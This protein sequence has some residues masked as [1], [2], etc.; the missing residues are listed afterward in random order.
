MKGHAVPIRKLAATAVPLVLAVIGLSACTVEAGPTV[1]GEKLA[2]AAADALEGQL[3][4]RPEVD[5]GGD[6]IIVSQGKKVDCLM[7][8]PASGS[9]F[10]ATVTFTGVDGA[11]WNITV[12]VAAEPN[13]SGSEPSETDTTESTSSGAA[14]EIS[15]EKLAAAAADA[16]EG[17]I[18]TRPQIDCGDLNLTIYEGRKT[19]CQLID[20]STGAEYEVTISVTSIDGEAFE[21]DVQVANT[22][23]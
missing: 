11:E 2:E 19:Y 12:D 20:S 22:P 7:T 5:C 9:E 4:A 13:G 8:D 14:L 16:L 3:G 17:E 18:G 1:S 15:A 21:F 10:D 23:G 6:D